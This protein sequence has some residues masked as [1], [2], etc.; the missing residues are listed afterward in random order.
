MIHRRASVRIAATLGGV[1]IQ[2]TGVAGYTTLLI[3]M[4]STTTLGSLGVAAAAALVAVLY[5]PRGMLITSMVGFYVFPVLLLLASVGAFLFAWAIN[6]RIGPIVPLRI[7]T[8][9]DNLT[10]HKGLRERRI[11]LADVLAFDEDACVIVTRQYRAIPLA[12]NT[13]PA[14]RVRVLRALR[15]AFR[16]RTSGDPDAIPDALRALRRAEHA[17]D[18]A[19]T[20]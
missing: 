1:N 20:P 18:C 6:H 17:K 15:E 8:H 3:S 13:S 12:P 4:L 10:I 2:V 9:G 16:D 11:P 7:Q 19:P 5:L 14:D